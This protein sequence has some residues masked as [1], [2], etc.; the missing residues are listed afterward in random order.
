[1]FK[2][3]TLQRFMSREDHGGY[4]GIFLKEEL[5]KATQSVKDREKI[6]AIESFVRSLPND[7]ELGAAIRQLM[8]THLEFTVTGSGSTPHSFFNHD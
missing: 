5:S 8:Y 1:M 6:N 3:P 2:Q 7:Q 4:D